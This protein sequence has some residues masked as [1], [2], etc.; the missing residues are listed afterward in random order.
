MRYPQCA[1][2]GLMLANTA[3]SFGKVHRPDGGAVEGAQVEFFTVNF[4]RVW[5][6]EPL[7]PRLET[8]AA[9]WA[10]A[11]VEDDTWAGWYYLNPYAQDRLNPG[12]ERDL[13]I[14]SVWSRVR[15]TKPL[16]ETRLFYR[17]N[18]YG[19]CPYGVAFSATPYSGGPYP[20]DL[21]RV[22]TA[23]PRCNVQSFEL[24][25]GTEYTKEPDLIVDPRTLL[26][27][28][29]IHDPVTGIVPCED[30]VYPCLRYSTGIAN[31]G[32]GDLWVTAPA[33]DLRSV[34][35][36]LFRADGVSYTS[37][38]LSTAA[39]LYHPEHRHFH[40]G[41]L[42]RARLRRVA[43]ECSTEQTAENCP[44]L[45]AT[46]KTSF[47]LMDGAVVDAELRAQGAYSPVDCD[48]PRQPGNY[49]SQGIGSGREDVYDYFVPGQQLDIRG[50]TPGAYWLE[51][52]VNPDHAL[53]ESDY[54]NNV[55]R[56]V[57]SIP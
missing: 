45:R 5:D 35:Q 14:E 41:E 2:L 53:I 20:H 56:V 3:C 37:L 42:T 15:V 50:L 12:D 47:C 17:Q 54:A 48:R 9:S 36:R 46:Q 18:V 7:L 16:F 26:A 29:V 52:E 1:V 6:G 23:S 10:A 39:F 33:D 43:P 44:V 31:V 25:S 51:A 28:Y 55:S 57:I 49:L 13:E 32:W 27:H 19:E 22:T 24:P 21:G 30:N 38:P 34:T 11:D 8:H 40:F 4:D